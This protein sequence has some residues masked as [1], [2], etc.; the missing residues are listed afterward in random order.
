[1]LLSQGHGQSGFFQIDSDFLQP[2]LLVSLDLRAGRFQSQIMVLAVTVS[3]EIA[4]GD[5]FD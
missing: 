5:V 1:M 4:L 2:F 3:M